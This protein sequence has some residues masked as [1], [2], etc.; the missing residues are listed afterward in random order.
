MSALGDTKTRPTEVERTAPRRVVP[1]SRT[2][3]TVRRTRLLEMLRQFEQSHLELLTLWAPAGAGKTTTLAYWAE[4]LRADDNR[5]LLVTADDL[6][7]PVEATLRNADWLF[8]DNVNALVSGPKAGPLLRLLTLAP[9][10]TRVVV[11]GRFEPAGFSAISDILGDRMT[12]PPTA[13]AFTVDETL[14][15]AL[16]FNLVLPIQDADV[17]TRRTGGWAAGLGL[18]MP[19]LLTQPDRSAA[20]TRF[21]GDHHQVADYLIVRVLDALDPADC[22]VLMRTAVTTA[23]PLDLAVTLTGRDDV[24]QILHRLAAQHLFVEPSP[25]DDGFAIH[26]ILTSYMRAEFRRRDEGAAVRNHTAAGLWYERR[27]LHDLALQQALLSHCPIVVADQLERSGTVLLMQGRTALVATALRMLPEQQD[28]LAVATIRLG[29]DA[30]AFPDRLGAEERL[31][32]AAQLLDTADVE[33]APR[34]RPIVLAL[35]SFLVTDKRIAEERLHE[36]G[37]YLRTTPIL[38]L[39]AALVVRAAIAWCL[40]TA[41]HRDDAEQLLRTVQ[42]A[43]LRAGYAWLYII[44][45][46]ASATLAV[47]NGDWRTASSYEEQMNAVQFDTTAPYNRA[48]ARAMLVAAMH[49]YAR[50]EPVSFTPLHRIEAADPNGGEL[51]LLFQVRALLA[52][53][54][55][56]AAP[57]PREP[58]ARLVHLVRVDGRTHR[59]TVAA[60][61]TR[62]HFWTLTLHGP[63]ASADVRR[64]LAELLGA[65]SLEL[66]TLRLLAANR[67]DHLAELAV[68]EAVDGADAAWTGISVVHAHL[69]LASHAREHGRSMEAAERVRRAL[70]VSE[71]FGYAR[72]FLSSAG[73]G[74]DLVQAYRGS[75]GALTDYA[76]H[77]ASLA[78]PNQ[79]E[80]GATPYRLPVALTPKEQELLLELPAHQTVAEIAAKHHLSVNT[81]KT[82]L[83]SIYLK[84]SA[85]GRTEA[86]T[87][88]R[89]RGLL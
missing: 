40:I 14:A 22:D 57:V 61:A 10:G 1:F 84:L 68:A 62:L 86:V 45:V 19:F 16:R 56:D 83:R 11:S 17:L 71:E 82:H 49:A 88:A 60:A 34:W 26:P 65:D 87:I 6:R 67:N 43:A 12:V 73:A 28:T 38:S 21:D 13:L 7:T 8:I 63:A 47:R 41:E 30:P 69:A 80:P 64:L 23:V 53:A 27:G 9:P 70:D 74:V 29:M 77:I 42:A 85:T 55:I 75:Y 78:V 5:V 79:T 32:R 81:I 18:A 48:T 46:D 2:G 15:L 76:E 31:A 66:K 52:V 24:G 3:T 25:D 4:E 59:R 39:D 20:I 51:G 33:T 35:S 58:L 37:D 44:A 72:E 89:E 50:C 36:L 54:A